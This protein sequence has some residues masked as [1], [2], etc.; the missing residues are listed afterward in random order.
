[1]PTSLFPLHTPLPQKHTPSHT[2]PSHANNPPPSSPHT[3]SQIASR[4]WSQ[5][6]DSQLLAKVH[7]VTQMSP[8]NPDH[9]AEGKCSISRAFQCTCNLIS[10][11]SKPAFR[12]KLSQVGHS[13]SEGDE[14][15]FP[16]LCT[17]HDSVASRGLI[18]MSCQFYNVFPLITHTR[19]P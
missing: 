18:P 15:D 1:M 11:S 5:H 8:K 10:S 2:D 3:I 12:S 14:N 13:T 4:P 19:Q 9:K 16:S 6:T 17:W 7:G